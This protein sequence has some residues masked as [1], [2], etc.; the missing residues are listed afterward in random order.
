M[1]FHYE[2][3]GHGRADATLAIEDQVAAVSA[4]YLGDALGDLLTPLVALVRGATAARASW[5][6]EP[7]E[8]RWLFANESGRARVRVLAFPECRDFVDAPDADGEVLVDAVC[9]LDALVG[10]IAEG[11]QSV[12]D[13]YGETGYRQKWG[14]HAFPISSL[15]AIS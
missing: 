5:D 7:G 12:L 11:A 8:F 14:K 1:T 10:A 3:R 6:E 9:D 13:L 15:R 4:S 2:L